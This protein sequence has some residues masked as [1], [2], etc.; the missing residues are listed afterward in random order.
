MHSPLMYSPLSPKM[1]ALAGAA[2]GLL[3]LGIYLA[4]HSASAA[5]PVSKPEP[6]E[7]LDLTEVNALPDP[8]PAAAKAAL[9]GGFQAPAWIQGIEADS[10]GDLEYPVREAIEETQPTLRWASSSPINNVAILDSSHQLVARAELYGDTHWT[11]PVELERGAI[12]MWEVAARDQVR[13]SFFRV[14]DDNEAG[15]LEGIRMNHAQSHLVLGVSALQLGLL[16]SAQREFQALV[17][18]KPHSPEAAQL[19]RTANGLRD[20]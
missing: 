8:F 5:T 2:A 4:H 1:L 3:I 19:L 16:S 7:H 14:L 11:V 20:H 17:Q 6:V 13:R 9:A 15:L 12:Y 18:E 10:G